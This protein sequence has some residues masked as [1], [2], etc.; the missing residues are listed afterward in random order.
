MLEARAAAVASQT[1][2]SGSSSPPTRCLSP[3]APASEAVE[4][5]EHPAPLPQ[6]HATQVR[7]PRPRDDF[8]DPAG[9]HR[10]ATEPVGGGKEAS[11]DT[12]D[13]QSSPPRT[14][15][16]TPPPGPPL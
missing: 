10:P 1:A 8:A 16:D 4:P 2:F 7:T 13:E 5:A 14:R 12:A 3:I 9:G 15:H 11:Q 6:Q